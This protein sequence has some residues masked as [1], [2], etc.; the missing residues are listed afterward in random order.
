MMHEDPLH[1]CSKPPWVIHQLG[2][3]SVGLGAHTT[4]RT[5]T[6]PV[7]TDPDT[8]LGS[9]PRVDEARAPTLQGWW[10]LV[11]CCHGGS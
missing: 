4:P 8:D 10:W 5:D 6:Q 11:E 3:D 2:M 1:S 7:A 9:L